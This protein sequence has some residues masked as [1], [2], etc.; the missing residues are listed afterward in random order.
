VPGAADRGDF[1][2][3]S[4]TIALTPADEA[5]SIPAD[6]LSATFERYWKDF[7][8]RRDGK[9]NWTDYT[10]YE[11]RLVG[12]YLRL[13]QPERARELLDYFM[14]DQRPAGW[15][16]WA[17]VVGRAPREPRF[18]GDM[19]HA[20]IAS[21]YV[22]S[23]LDMFAYDRPGDGTLLLGAGVPETWCEGPGFA[24][25]NLRTPYGSLNLS[26]KP[27]DRGA[28]LRVDGDAKPPGGFLLRSPWPHPGEAH[29]ANGQKVEWQNGE[30]PIA[31]LPA[32]IVVKPG[33]PSPDARG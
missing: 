21:D 30:L 6:L 27:E 25:R 11:L 26:C 10:P 12:T 4:T 29:L 7:A 9:A 3:A 19:P 23:V 18:I 16:Q 2:A 22:R 24:I 5:R 28:V 32:E 15:N 33:N 13:G 20:W 1:D 14:K 8:E 17:E 31:H